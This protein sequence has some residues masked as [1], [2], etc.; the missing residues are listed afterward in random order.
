MY[1]AAVGLTLRELIYDLGG[2]ILGDRE[3]LGRDPRR[4]VVPGAPARRGRQPSERSAHG[5]LATART[6]WTCRSASTPSAR[7]AACSAPAA[8]SCS[9]TRP[10]QCSRCTT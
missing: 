10:I 4:L 9:A 3:L 2:G 5:G 6:S 8:P 7:W 1:E